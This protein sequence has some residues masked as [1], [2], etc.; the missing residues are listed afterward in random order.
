M[1][2]ILFNQDTMLSI[3]VTLQVG[4]RPLMG[5]ILFNVGVP[6]TAIER[7]FLKEFP[8]PNGDYFI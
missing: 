2:L 6:T 5:I 4:F 1:G 7:K 8:S 3:I